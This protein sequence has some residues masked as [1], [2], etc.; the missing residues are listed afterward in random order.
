MAETLDVFT[1][2]G[3]LLEVLVLA[4]V[5]DRV[6]DDDAVDGVIGVGGE[7][8]AFEL[9]AVEFA[10]GEL[11]S[12]AYDV[13]GIFGLMQ[14]RVLCWWSESLTFLYRSVRSS[15]R[16][17]VRLGRCLR[18]SRRGEG[19]FGAWR[20]RRILLKGGIWLWFRRG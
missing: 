7:D 20:D 2:V 5:E 14:A 19:V 10:Q 3:N 16:T 11:A 13:S 12:T 6:V 15:L 18:G 8:G 9:F 4:V 17:Y 1:D